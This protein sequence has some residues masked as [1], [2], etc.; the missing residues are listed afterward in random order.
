MTAL[1]TGIVR[2]MP[3]YKKFL[4][5][6]D[7][8]T[9]FAFDSEPFSLGASLCSVYTRKLDILHR[10]YSGYTS[11]WGIKVLKD[12]LEDCGDDIAIAT[13]FFGSND[14]CLGGPQTV[15]ID[16]YISNMKQLVIML[17]EKNIKPILVG[18]ALFN[19]ELW[20]V[21]KED[22]IKMGYIRTAE[23]LEKY[24]IALEQLA[25]E[26]N[27]PFV[28]LHRAFTIHGGQNWKELLLDGLH[29]SGKG[30]KV[31]YD[32]LLSVIK[33]NYLELYPDNMP[34]LYPDWRDIEPDGSNL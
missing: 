7:S 29:F 9:Q 8:I 4:L 18:P 32:E 16:E 30:N 2:D 10:G 3:G 28:N 31:W 33:I 13:L 15:P 22:D 1:T 11:R 14:S 5:F 21:I 17:R 25:Q 24:G 27:V 34:V 6:G 23:N 12:I 26:E 19:R 20:E